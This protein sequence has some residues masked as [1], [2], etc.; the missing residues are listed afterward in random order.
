MLTGRGK[1]DGKRKESNPR[2]GEAE[3][4][5][6]AAEI[7]PGCT[8]AGACVQRAGHATAGAM[9]ATGDWSVHIYNLLPQRVA[10]G[11]RT[12]VS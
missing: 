1:A 10:F 4:V 2:Q 3:G 9:H 5:N 6:P 7:R 11:R 12:Y 8:V